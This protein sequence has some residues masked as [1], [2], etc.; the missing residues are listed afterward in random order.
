A[1]IDVCIDL[2][3]MEGN[4]R[5]MALR[6]RIGARMRFF[7]NP[8]MRS[9]GERVA[10]ASGYTGVMN[11]DARIEHITGRVYL[12][13]SNPRYWATVSASAGAGLNFVA[14]SIDPPCNG[15][16]ARM[17]TQGEF[18]TRHPLIRPGA[19]APML[20]DS[21]GH[22]RLLRA[23]MTD[24]QSVGGAIKSLAVKPARM[25]P[26]LLARRRG[27]DLYRIQRR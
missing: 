27:Q 2:L 12:L 8:R 15:A 10:A 17:L 23:R 25:L 4:I 7:D 18:H 13:E 11:L 5:A 26:R 14:L 3:A 24:M 19:W 9:L 22:G 1:G 16:P 20:F 6:E 21:G